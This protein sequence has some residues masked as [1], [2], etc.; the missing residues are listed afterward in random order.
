MRKK[1]NLLSA[2][3][4]ECNSN[5]WQGKSKT[6]VESSKTI[7]TISL[8]FIIWVLLI[9]GVGTILNIYQ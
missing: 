4:K 1:I 2:G 9:Y 6:Q 5:H 3:S 7:I 8:I